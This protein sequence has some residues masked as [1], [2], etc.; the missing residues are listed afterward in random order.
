MSAQDL[1]VARSARM[2]DRQREETALEK[3]WK[4]SI[5][6]PRLRIPPTRQILEPMRMLSPRFQEANVR[7]IGAS[8][9]VHGFPLKDADSLSPLGRMVQARTVSMVVDDSNSPNIEVPYYDDASSYSR[10][11][12]TAPAVA[13]VAGANKWILMWSVRVTG[14]EPWALTIR[15]MEMQMHARRQIIWSVS[16]N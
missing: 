9:E 11:R 13:G 6:G 4:L 10:S 5:V 16:E 2:Q 1:I 8:E 7:L 15:R 14:S 3:V 12:R